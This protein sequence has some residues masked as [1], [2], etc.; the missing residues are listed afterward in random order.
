MI[1][2]SRSRPRLAHR[3]HVFHGES[4][5]LAVGRSGF[6]W[7]LA[8]SYHVEVGRVVGVSSKRATSWTEHLPQDS[9]ETRWEPT[10]TAEFLDSLVGHKWEALYTQYVYTAARRAEWLGAHREALKDGG[11]R[12]VG[13]VRIV[14]RK[15]AAEGLG[16][17]PVCKIQHQGR[18]L[19][20]RTKNLTTKKGKVKTRR[21]PVPVEGMELL[22][23]HLADQAE[24]RRKMGPSYVDHFLIFAE[25]DGSPILPGA[26]TKEFQRLVS[27][28]GLPPIRLHD[29][30]HNA[31]S[32][33]LAAGIQPV[34]VAKMTGHDP[35]VLQ[36][37]Y[38]H[39]SP[40]LTDE[41]FQRANDTVTR[42]RGHT[43]NRAVRSLQAVR[44]ATEVG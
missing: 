9:F 14:S 44:P 28:A 7:K 39:L 26:V 8:G 23:R 35:V 1:L 21:L 38:H 19:V 42:L 16:V 13:T 32:L 31:A 10:Q 2:I 33:F 24:H 6:A 43:G 34:V 12:V 37:I 4:F 40:E 18:V 17:C 3:S 15:D 30:R 36:E 20:R 41:M 27:E 22:N 11:L 29:L 25:D 5:S